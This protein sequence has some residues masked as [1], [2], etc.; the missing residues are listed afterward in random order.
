MGFQEFACPI[1]IAHLRVIQLRMPF[2]LCAPNMDITRILH[3]LYLT[4]P[5]Y[6]EAGRLSSISEST[7]GSYRGR[8]QGERKGYTR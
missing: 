7:P 2:A 1:W 6:N 3:G 5:F 8:N 4:A